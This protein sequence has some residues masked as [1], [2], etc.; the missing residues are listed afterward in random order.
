MI[1]RQAEIY[2]QEGCGRC[3]LGG[4]PECKVHKWANELAHLR[5]IILDCGLQEDCKWGSPCYTFQGKNIIMLATFK[6]YCF[7]DFFNGAL[8]KDTEGILVRQTENVQAGRQ[9]RF[10][11][12]KEILALE[13]TLKTYIFEAI[14]VEKSGQKVVLK[15]TSDFPVPAELEQILAADP[16]FKQA[17]EVLTPGRQRG[18][19]LHFAA[20]KQ[21]QTRSSRI[22]KCREKI[23]AGK[24][25]QD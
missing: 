9:V 1:T 17:W 21:A 5:N 18:Y 15:K 20:P 11:N 24:G 2:F 6:E 7:V 19:L 10:T 8:L 25:L 12:V 22:E 13:L 16:T 4:T 23:F 3:S 14:E